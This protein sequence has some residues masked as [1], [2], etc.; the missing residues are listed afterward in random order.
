[1][2]KIELSALKNAASL[3]GRVVN[4]RGILPIL[5][6][7]RITTEG[8]DTVRL[9]GTDTVH[10]L[11]VIAPAE[12]HEAFDVCVPAERLKA[13]AGLSGDR[14]RIKLDEE[15]K[16]LE[17]SMGTSRFSM[18]YCPGD[19]QPEMKVEGNVVAEFEAPGLVDLIDTVVFAVAGTKEHGRSYLQN[20][21]IESDGSAIH[22]VGADNAR[23]VVNSLPVATPEFGVPISSSTAKELAQLPVSRFRVSERHLIAVGEGI[24][25]VASRPMSNYILWRNAFPKPV[26]SA[27]VPK[28]ALAE[29]C[30]IHRQFGTDGYV[31]FETEG[32]ECVIQSRGA[33]DDI[34]MIVQIDANSDEAL[35]TAGFSASLLQ[36]MID[37]VSGDSVEF[38][39]AQNG[40]EI[41][42]AIQSGS[43]RGVIA[44]IKQ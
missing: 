12:V 4:T 2:L 42:R 39:W 43:W 30:A 36:P 21:W 23:V 17:V 6:M 1:M 15:R 25:F 8:T 22:L 27:K 11:S 40:T 29:I 26:H 3:A 34:E 14:V 32:H 13:V 10:T 5:S 33:T 7:V 20:L 37:Q 41:P 16:K 19:M 24:R 38:L 31:R 18:A 9:T 44:P 28:A 35:L